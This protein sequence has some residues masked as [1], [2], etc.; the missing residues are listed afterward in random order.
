MKSNKI[1]KHS[2]R[3]LFLFFKYKWNHN[4]WL[5]C[6]CDNVDIH[7]Q[8]LQSLHLKPSLLQKVWVLI[9]FLT[10]VI[11]YGFI[12]LDCVEIFDFYRNFRSFFLSNLIFGLIINFHPILFQVWI[13]LKSQT[14]SFFFQYFLKGIVVSQKNFL[15]LLWSLKIFVVFFAFFKKCIGMKIVNFFIENFMDWC[16][17]LGFGKIILPIQTEIHN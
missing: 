6:N 5:H 4:D 12:Q 16:N 17:V 9:W 2:W 1:K 10:L 11:F 13:Y 14:H 3:N 8:S 7:C 15:R